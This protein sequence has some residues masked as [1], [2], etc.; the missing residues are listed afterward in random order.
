MKLLMCV[1][2]CLF[3]LAACQKELES[4]GGPLPVV[5]DSTL[6]AMYVELDTTAAA[7]LDTIIKKVFY[8][9]NA[10]RNNIV[11]YVFYNAG[12]AYL[13]KSYFFFIGTDTLP[14]KRVDL[15]PSIP[16]SSPDNINDTTYYFYDNAVLK[17]DSI[18][19][20]AAQTVRLVNKYVYNATGIIVTT[21]AYF[22]GNPVYQQVDTIAIER[23]N[24]N[25]SK[26]VSTRYT[27]LP[28]TYR[29]LYDNHPNQFHQTAE[30]DVKPFYFPETYIEDC[31]QKNNLVE[32]D[33]QPQTF[34]FKNI[35]EYHVNGYPKL[36]R[37][38]DLSNPALYTKGLYFYTL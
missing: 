13:R 19:S 12:A 7:P 32:L 3:L 26:Q 28:A 35:Y 21:T 2:S 5:E 34:Q 8:Y 30:A 22:P 37:I 18:I 17:S 29:Y 10:K 14:F 38:Y 1:L 11:D 27:S 4:E 23:T 20:I 31:Y 15:T 24:G 16:A 25:I 36:V 6:L 9:D 33:E